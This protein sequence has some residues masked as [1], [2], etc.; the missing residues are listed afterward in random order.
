[1]TT[2]PGPEPPSSES[3]LP[4]PAAPVRGVVARLD[5]LDRRSSRAVAVGWPH[6]RWFSVPLSLFSRSA[7]YG[8]LW[9]VVAL[10]P[11]LTDGDRPWATF[12]YV[13]VAVFGVELIGAAIKR[14]VGRHRPTVADPTQTVQIPLPVSKSFPSSHASMSV[15]AS[16]TLGSLHPSWLPVLVAITVVLCFSRVYLG[17]HYIADVLGGVVLGVLSGVLILWLVPSPF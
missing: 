15:V 11:L 12:I 17:V 14:Q 9:Y 3:P 10:I 8:V 13:S 7:N 1:M 6:P 4:E 2:P 5:D 16:F